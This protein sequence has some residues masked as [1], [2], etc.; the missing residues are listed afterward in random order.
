MLTSYN[1]E[2]GGVLYLI[3]IRGSVVKLH[4]LATAIWIPLQ[5]KDCDLSIHSSVPGINLGLVDQV[6]EPLFDNS[7]VH[8]RALRGAVQLREV[9]SYNLPLVI[10]QLL[11]I[12]LV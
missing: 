4:S 7:P 5:W 6:F 12:P 11:V 10:L 8:Y 2:V 3:P 9:H 1:E